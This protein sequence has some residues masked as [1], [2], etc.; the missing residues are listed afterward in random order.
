MGDKETIAYR[1]GGLKEMQ[2]LTN[3]LRMPLSILGVVARVVFVPEIVQVVIAQEQDRLGVLLLVA[4]DRQ[5]VGIL[6]LARREALVRIRIEVVAEE[7]IDGVLANELLPS[8][9]TMDV[10]NEIEFH[11]LRG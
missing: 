9:A 1:I 8:G 5:E 7:N 11:V 6:L 3:E 2:M 4:D 10:A